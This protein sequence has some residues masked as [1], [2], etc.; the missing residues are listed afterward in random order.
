MLYADIAS[1]KVYKNQQVFN[2]P[3]GSKKGY[4]EIVFVC[5]PTWKASLDFIANGINR[6]VMNGYKRYYTPTKY[7]TRIGNK[8]IKE[9]RLQTVK[10]DYSEHDVS[11]ELTLVTHTQ[12]TNSLERKYSLV[13]DV[14]YWNE[15]WL[16]YHK[17]L[18]AEVIVTEYTNLLMKELDNLQLKDYHK[19]LLIPIDLWAKYGE[20]GMTKDYLDDPISIMLCSLYRFPEVGNQYKNIEIYLVDASEH[21]FMKVDASNFTKKTMSLFKSKLNQLTSFKVNKYEAALTDQDGYISD[22]SLKNIEDNAIAGSQTR[23]NATKS[24]VKDKL[25]E[26]NK[27]AEESKPEAIQNAEPVSL[28]VNNSISS[29]S[30]PTM[31]TAG[32]DESKFHV[33]STGS[34][35]ESKKKDESDEEVDTSDIIDYDESDDDTSEDSQQIE[36]LDDEDVSSEDLP[37]EIQDELNAATPDESPEEVAAKVKK[38]V[39]ITKFKPDLSDEQQERISKFMGTQDSILKQSASTMEK[40]IIPESDLS[41]VIHTSN[42]NLS[43][44]K[45]KNFHAAYNTQNMD[46]DIDNAVA[47][48]SKADYPLVIV[49][50]KVED[51]SD[52][53]NLKRTYSYTLKDQFGG[54]HHIVFDVPILIDDQYIYLGGNKKVIQN[55]MLLKP[56]IKSSPDEVQIV[57]FYNKIFCKRKNGKMDVKS[58]ALMKILM[59]EEGI[60]K[61]KVRIGNSMLKNKGQHTPLDFDIIAKSISQCTIGSNQY[62][63]DASM[64]LEQIKKMKVKNG[65]PEITSIHDHNGMMIGYNTKTHEILYV[66]ENDSVL[67]IL[68]NDLPDESKKKLAR[69]IPS[70]KKFMY[71]TA[72]LLSIEFPIAFV[73]MYC[74]GLTETL[75]RSKVN[76][77]IVEPNTKY[78]IFNEGVIKLQDKWII[79]DRYPYH[80]SLIFNGCEYFNLR[81][82]TLEEADSKSTYISLLGDFSKRRALNQFAAAMDQFKDFMIDPVSAEVLRDM[83]MPDNFV[84]LLVVAAIKLN[85]RDTEDATDMKNVRI[86]SSEIFVQFIYYDLVM[87]YIEYRKSITKRKPVRVSVNKNLVMTHIYGGQGGKLP[88]CQ[89]IEDASV[90]NPVLELEKKGAVSYRGP[91]GI[92]KARAM[93]L[94]KRSYD[95]SMI[96]TIAVSTSPDANV[97]IQRQLTLDPAITSTRGYIKPQDEDTIEEENNVNLMCPAELLSPPGALHDDSHRTSMSYKQSKY[98]VLTA[99]SCPVLVGNKVEEAVPYYS[100]KEFCVTAKKKGKVIDKVDDLYIVEYVDGTREAFSTAPKEQKNSAGGFYIETKFTTD[101]E[102]GD[103]FKEGQVLAWNPRA[104]TKNRNGVTASMN[105]GVLTKVAVLPNFDEYE[106]SAPITSKLAKRLATTIVNEEAIVVSKDAFIQSIV[107]VGDHVEVGDVLI[108]YDNIKDDEKYTNMLTN[109]LS[110]FGEELIGNSVIRKTAE[111]GGEIADIKFYSASDLSDLSDTLK[112]LVSAYWK[113]LKRVENALD[114]Y[115]NPDDPATYKCGE[116]ITELPGKTETKFGKILGHQ[117]DDGVLIRIFIKHTDLVKKGDK[118]TNYTALK[119]IVSNVIEEGYE[120][121]SELNPNEEISTMI[122]PSAILARKTPSVFLSEWG[123]KIMIE[124]KRKMIETYFGKDYIEKNNIS[125]Y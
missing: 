104:F 109:L 105:I 27:K 22:A 23:K 82:Y 110:E 107:K 58:D 9:L 51:S 99:D 88:A 34:E 61:F 53:M 120:P 36:E 115:A 25:Q 48:L 44:P 38:N 50:K 43:K 97:G 96:G 87:A 19:T 46:S 89:M 10:K 106:D 85:G 17:K 84:D 56:I 33:M 65:D 11:K 40:K 93:N 112:P 100:G 47:I 90:L 94:P 77:R 21:Q 121:F 59:S 14:S 57:T 15:L 13:Y 37:D 18:S 78:D 5:A 45:A 41:K 35:K 119:G 63:F 92:N 102:V 98:M 67:D 72:K 116:L 1:N 29:S 75:K 80:N 49:D 81:N 39:L 86:R 60:Q 62:I 83:N 101:L 7:Y 111:H 123:N 76:Y 117:V 124:L 54:E 66:K 31:T 95:K 4:G 114:K 125:L 28:T 108:A 32:Q 70:T 42:K 73:M 3:I 79:W 12:Y 64:L 6:W 55:Q 2:Y 103:T 68:I 122:A 71:A 24:D 118:V 30:T 20:F 91:S 69:S 16:K 8:N 113:K 74:V 26:E 52:T